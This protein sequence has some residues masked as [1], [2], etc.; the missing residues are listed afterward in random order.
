MGV[1]SS[2]KAA[3]PNVNLETTNDLFTEECYNLLQIVPISSLFNLKKAQLRR[4][5]AKK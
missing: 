3:V 4:F 2:S 5:F 1:K